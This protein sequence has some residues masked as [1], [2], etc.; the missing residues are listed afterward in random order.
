MLF[1]VSPPAVSAQVYRG[2]PK[3][4]V[5]VVIDQLRGDYLNRDH[6][7]FKGRGFGSLWTRRVVYR[8]RSSRASIMSL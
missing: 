1:F 5:V 3:L 2:K 4:I 6:D 7:K 8:R